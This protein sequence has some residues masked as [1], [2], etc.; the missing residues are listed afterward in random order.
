MNARDITQHRGRTFDVQPTADPRSEAWPVQTLLAAVAPSR[1]P[2]RRI[3]KR[4]PVLDQGAEGAC[5]PAGTMVRLANGAQR[6]IEDLRLLDQV[7]TAE[8]GTGSVTETM[9]RRA[10]SLVTLRIEGS[11]P[12]RCT[13]EHP[14]LTDRG[15]VAAGHLTPGDRVAAT[16]YLP[17][18]EDL[19][20]V[21]ALVDT[22]DLRGTVSGV[23]NTG[24]VLTT[25]APL[26]ALLARTPAMGRLIGLYAA[27]GHTTANKVVWTYGGHETDTLVTDTVA[28]VKAAFDAEARVQHRP[29]GAVNVVLY[30]KTWRRLF[31]ALAPGTSKHGDKHLSEH[32]THGPVEYLTAL[33]DGWIDG[34]GHQRRNETDGVTVSRRLALDMHAIANGLGRRPCV[35]QSTPASNRHAATRQTRYDVR[36]SSALGNR[37]A[38]MTDGATWRPVTAVVNEAYDGWVYNIEVEGDHSYVADGIGVHNCVGHGVAGELASSPHRVKFTGLPDGVPTDAQAFAFWCYRK[39]QTLDQWPGEDY[40]GTSVNAGM[41]VARDLGLIESWRWAKTWTDLRD[42][43]I[44]LGPVVLAIPWHDGMY[45]AK[46]AH[47]KVTG[48]QVGWHCILAN[49]YDPSHRLPGKP[50][51]TERVRLLNSWGLGYGVRGHAWIDRS[52]LEGL[53]AQGAEM[54]V[55]LGRTLTS[56]VVSPA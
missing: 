47:L 15:Y 26:P 53:M 29:N 8:G 49:G 16:R 46:R 33:L 21:G 54:V 20:D 10:D 25:I 40:S 14:I 30:G 45:E 6:R 38:L 44:N 56:R 2:R 13:P 18:S 12:L 34:D 17:T 11:L 24:G 50:D 55:P 32:V 37:S 35:R 19:I 43:L 9:V 28:L 23:V 39:A 48:E 22:R 36:W 52:D 3:W 31:E 1:V 51:P 42:S 27:E 5:F 41:I 7:V 4:G